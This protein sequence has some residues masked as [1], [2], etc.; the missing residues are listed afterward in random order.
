MAWLAYLQYLLFWALALGLFGVELFALVDAL[1]HPT[2]SFDAAL[3]KSKTFWAA[4]LG[5]TALLGFLSLPFS[6]FGLGT[7]GM[8]LCVVPAG[9]YLADVRPAIA[10]LRR[11]R[12]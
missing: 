11:G 5:V 2:A 9:I 3:K 10:N 4:L 7:F 8:M 1:R 12:W 6:R